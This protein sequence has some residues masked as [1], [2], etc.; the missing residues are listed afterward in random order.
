MTEGDRE[1]EI[2]CGYTI[3]KKGKKERH[4]LMNGQEVDNSL[5]TYYGIYLD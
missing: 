1:R 3:T 5:V 4:D 2:L